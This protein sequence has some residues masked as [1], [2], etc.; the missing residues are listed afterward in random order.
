VSVGKLS[1][2]ETFDLELKIEFVNDNLRKNRIQGRYRY[3]HIVFLGFML[4]LQHLR[5]C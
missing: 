5:F 2:F 4:S 3:N 1:E